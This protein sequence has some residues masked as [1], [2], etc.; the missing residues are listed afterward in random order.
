MSYSELTTASL[1]EVFNE[2]KHRGH[3]IATWVDMPQAGDTLRIDGD[4]I[5]IIDTATLQD[6]MERIAYTN[7]SV[8]RDQ[9]PFEYVAQAIND[10]PDSEEAWERYQAGIDEGIRAEIEK[11]VA[12]VADTWFSEE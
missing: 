12:A 11:R 6:A 7:E 9:S 2:G 3:N 10:R 1:K 4:R 5:E 8:G